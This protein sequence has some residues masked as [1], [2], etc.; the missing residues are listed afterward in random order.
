M[1]ETLISPDDQ[2]AL[3]FMVEEAKLAQVALNALVKHL[4]QKY[5]IQAPDQLLP[6]GQIQRV[7][8]PGP[9]PV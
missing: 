6:S 9:A 5:Q 8:K 2:Q 1:T 4:G 3:A 7:P